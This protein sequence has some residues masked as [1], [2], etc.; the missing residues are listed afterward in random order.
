[1]RRA[2][3]LALCL[4]VL[5]PG[6]A[7]AEVI[8]AILATV[9]GDPVTLYELKRFQRD[10]IRARQAGITNQRELL[11]ALIM[12]K[13]V[14]REVSA[15]GVIVRDEDVTAYING[16]KE[17]N[18]ISDEKLQEALQAQGL[19]MEQ[20]RRQIRE[21]LQRQQLMAREIRGKVSVSPEEIERYY[22]A[23]ADEYSTPGRTEISHIVFRL[24]EDASSDQVAAISAKAEEVR[25]QIDKGLD[26]AEAARRYSEDASGK[27]GGHLG[28]FKKGELLEPME[29]AADKLKVGEVSS[30]VRTRLGLHLVRVDA[31]ET[32]GMR[33]LAELQD[34]IKQQLYQQAV[35]QRMQ[36]WFSEE[37]Y[38]RHHVQLLP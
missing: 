9:D 16:I 33:D 18:K 36:K 12:Q 27:D 5:A 17:R 28:W 1:M 8:N 32:A 35:E 25:A 7:A 3:F 38:Q 21:D 22:K 2:F 37:L 15:Q 11:D 24:P 13:V 30:P 19:S 20:Y 31:R 23:H 34:E 4:A 10:D 14:E 29:A 26:F 6:T